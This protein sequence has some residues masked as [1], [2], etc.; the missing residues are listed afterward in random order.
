[1]SGVTPGW[2]PNVEH[3]KSW[4]LYL[5]MNDVCKVYWSV[6]SQDGSYSRSEWAEEQIAIFSGCNAPPV[7]QTIG[8]QAVEEG[9]TLEFY[10]SADDPNGDN[11]T[12]TYTD[13][14]EG[15]FFDEITGLFSWTPNY[16]QEG[17]YVVTFTATDDGIPS[18][19]AEMGVVITVG[20]VSDSCTL[21][22]V[23]I[24]EISNNSDIEKGMADSLISTLKQ[25]CTHI[26]ENKIKSSIN[27]LCN[28]IKKI[29][30]Y[31]SYDG[32]NDL[33]ADYYSAV[34]SDI[35]SNIGGE[36]LECN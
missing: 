28:F 34:A 18:E 23:L 32:I 2:H 36:P 9:S 10:V 6:Q 24:D 27:K 26:E 7:F 15:A 8:S 20:N 30:V 29:E 17:T 22:N 5:D 11:V 35:I 25:V 4:T 13:L 3:N 33:I 21:L 19:S 16:I 1:M 14:P 31:R 12:L